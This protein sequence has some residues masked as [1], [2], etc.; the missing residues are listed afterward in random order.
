[1]VE[2]RGRKLTIKMMTFDDIENV[3]YTGLE[4]AHRDGGG[5]EAPKMPHIGA[6]YGGWGG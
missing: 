3:V 2:D 4:G 1:M 6:I 5:V